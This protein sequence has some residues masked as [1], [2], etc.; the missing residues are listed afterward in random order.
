MSFFSV[1]SIDDIQ[2][3]IHENDSLHIQ[4][5]GTKT[6]LARTDCP[7]LDM[8]AVS[9]I[10]DYQADEY[11]FTA[12]AATPVAEIQAALSENGQYLP[13]DPLL[14]ES[15]ATLAGT[16]AANCS[17]SRRFRYGGVRDFLLGARVIDGQGRLF[18]VGGKVVKN[19]AGF[20]LA[21]FLVGSLGQYMLMV[22]VT[23]KV[24]PDKQAFLTYQFD[25]AKVE[26]ALNAIFYLNQ[27]VFELDALDIK[28]NRDGC[29][30]I[31]RF[32]GTSDTLSAQVKRFSAALNQHTNVQTMTPLEDAPYWREVNALHHADNMFKVPIAPKQIPALDAKLS[33]VN[34]SYTAGGNIAWLESEDTEMLSSILNHLNLSGLQIIGKS[35]NP[36]PGK[37]IDNIFSQKVKAVLDP[38]NKFI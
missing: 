18:R 11:T 38:N 31:A 17:G 30:L 36:I 2:T 6:G 34:R 35:G 4:A 28:V 16:I 25:Y 1:Q 26:E 24:F 37:S 32:A 21:K 22:D 12:Y 27:Q 23:F 13:C 29:S 5:N 9:G 10:I 7:I 14:V 19:A 20:D 8:R 15:G 3:A 33:K